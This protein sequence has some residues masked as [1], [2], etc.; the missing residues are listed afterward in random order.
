MCC[1]IGVS[2]L[3][4]V[5]CASPPDSV[6]RGKCSYKRVKPGPVRQTHIN[7]HTHA[8]TDT[9]SLPSTT[10]YC[11]QT[12][13]GG[14]F[15]SLSLP[16]FPECRCSVGRRAE[17]CVRAMCQIPRLW[18][19]A[20]LCWTPS[21]H[22]LSFPPYLLPS[23]SHFRW[24]ALQASSLPRCSP[25]CV[26]MRSCVRVPACLA[27]HRKWVE[28]V[29][30]RS[31]AWNWRLLQPVSMPTPSSSQHTHIRTH[32]DNLHNSS[33]GTTKTLQQGG[34]LSVPLFLSMF[35]SVSSFPLAVSSSWTQTLTSFSLCVHYF[36][37]FEDPELWL[38]VHTSPSIWVESSLCKH[39]MCA[40][41]K[42][43]KKKS[44]TLQC[45]VLACS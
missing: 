45:C 11:L 42:K 29:C 40:H 2:S 36:H 13:K 21:S 17:E 24:T 26:C 33:S 28:S 12:L 41:E 35:I 10:P 4:Q 34:R 30:Q 20:A 18:E 14:T 15:L 6:S 38:Q 9:N 19:S 5:V 31:S 39:K 25:E 16:P 23:L 22:P 32:K 27:A 37:L 3:Y 1:Q 44:H 7:T 8:N 43:K